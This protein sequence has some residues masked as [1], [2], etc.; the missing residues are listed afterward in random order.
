MVRVAMVGIVVVSGGLVVGL[1]DAHAQGSAMVG[2]L[3][4]VVRDKPTGEPA[5]GATIVATSPAL[6]GEQVTLSD[7]TGQYFITSLP[8]GM[9]TLTIYYA[10]AVF[11]R[12]NVLIQVG[13][14]VVVN[15]AVDSGTPERP[16]GEVSK[17][18]GTAPIVDQG[19]TKTGLT[20]TDDY[21]R[22]VPTARTFGGTAGQAAGAQA[23]NYGISFAG[24]TSSENTAGS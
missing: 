20:L 15:L 17:L 16:R 14:D 10:D 21:T 9:Y 18:T 6:Q 22:N 12:G 3:R 1:P 4:G 23:D 11:T 2:S 5:G 8:P 19:S 24:A 13:K 7:E